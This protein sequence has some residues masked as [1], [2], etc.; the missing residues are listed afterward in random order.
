MKTI[1]SKAFAVI[2][3]LGDAANDSGKAI[4]FMASITQF[5]LGEEDDDPLDL[6]EDAGIGEH[7]RKAFSELP[8]KSLIDFFNRTY[9][10]RLWIIQELALNHN[11]T[12]F[13]CGDRQF[14]RS[15]I[16]RTCNFCERNI[17][18]IDHLASPSLGHTV[19]TPCPVYGSVWATVYHVNK[20]LQNRDQRKSERNVDSIDHV[21]DLGRKANVTDT[22]DKVYG[23]LGI[24]P[25]ELSATVT[26]DYTESNP[27][28]EV[29]SQFAR[30]ILDEF[31][32][33]EPIISW[34]SYKHNSSLPSWVPDW[35]SPFSRKYVYWLKQR[36][37]SRS[38]NTPWS[39]SDNGRLLHSRGVIVDSVRS[40]SLP[41]SENIPFRAQDRTH[42]AEIATIEC[43][44]R[45]G[46]REH[47]TAAL[48]RTLVMHHPNSH[49]R[50]KTILDIYLFDWDQTESS[51]S[52]KGMNI[53]TQNLSWEPFD[54]FRHTNASFS[55][56]GH[57]FRDFFPDMNSASNRRPGGE[58]VLTKEAA[59]D[60]LISVLALL[61]RRLITTKEG[62]LGLAPEEAQ[63]S[64]VIAI[65]YGCNVP[66]VL[67]PHG[68][69]YLLIG[70]CYV[71]GIM[72]GEIVEGKAPRELWLEEVEITLS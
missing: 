54:R 5:T 17:Q 14:S 58:D 12:L 59:G 15:M 4:D 69:T 10:R 1:Y 39:I 19:N 41:L 49:N 6:W 28:S 30:N 57:M 46:S 51:D 34:C 67:R 8:W 63:K 65:L 66:V 21:L 24:L 25:G 13:L 61:S 68:D 31:K 23:I 52:L 50:K 2:V 7:R 37:A 45:Y 40:T 72:D 20:L 38:R 71:D 18:I 60:M 32:R 48:R 29:Y 35:S 53:I 11:M 26:P 33:L 56:F 55:V 42:A 70:E 62:F 3:W 47:L 36:K 64:D 16:I 22:R 9:W 43:F 44:H 27:V